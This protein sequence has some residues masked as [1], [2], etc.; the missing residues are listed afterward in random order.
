MI[1]LPRLLII[2]YAYPPLGGIAII[3]ALTLAKEAHKQGWETA[4]LA[5]ANDPLYLR[6]PSIETESPPVWAYRYP[7]Y[8]IINRFLRRILPGKRILWSFLDAF[9][10]WVPAARLV[11]KM[12]FEKWPYDAVFAS[13][14]RYSSLRVAA[15]LKESIGVAAIADLRDSLLYNFAIDYVHPWIRR[16]YHIYYNDLL[17]KFDMITAVDRNA[18]RGIDL[19]YKIVYNG[20]DEEEFRGDVPRYDEFTISYVGTY[21]PQFKVQG[22]LRALQTLPKAIRDSIRVQFV[23]DGSDIFKTEAREYGIDWIEIRNRV[24]RKEAIKI[25]RKS[26]A[27]LVLSG[28]VTNALGAK[29]FECARS[30]ATV[31]NLCQRGNLPWKFVNETNLATNVPYDNPRQIRNEILNAMKRGEHRPPEGIEKYSRQ[32]SAKKILSIIEDLISE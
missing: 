18:V 31:L 26:H 9:F 25:M 4:L 30:G 22:L 2:S 15:E 19:P 3:R 1:S 6:D 14:P 21:Y 5:V 17:S 16:F 10:D 12:L 23:G 32:E 8:L 7:I 13:A 29:I 27:L 28:A 24:P 20:Y 11:G